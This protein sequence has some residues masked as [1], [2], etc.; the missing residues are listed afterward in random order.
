M[1]YDNPDFCP[2]V[3]STLVSFPAKEW[4]SA[5]IK[6][7]LDGNHLVFIDEETNKILN[8]PRIKEPEYNASYEYRGIAPR[9]PK[10]PIN[11]LDIPKNDNYTAFRPRRT[12]F[13]HQKPK[14]H[15][16]NGQIILDTPKE[17]SKKY[18]KGDQP[19]QHP[20]HYS[21]KL[22]AEK[23]AKKLVKKPEV[24]P[25]SAREQPKPVRNTLF[26]RSLKPK[27]T[28]DPW[29]DPGYYDWDNDR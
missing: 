23:N 9:N 2:K 10:P 12:L 14:E 28:S 19:L 15:R 20:L 29:P 3:V 21:T 7:E 6:A 13:S 11:P 5:K 27:T 8:T 16:N 1:D 25:K 4:K 17:S 24:T 22:L 26:K 18:H